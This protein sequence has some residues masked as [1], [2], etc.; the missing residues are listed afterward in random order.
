M[1]S[2]LN[3]MIVDCITESLCFFWFLMGLVWWVIINHACFLL[4]ELLSWFVCVMY[5]FINFLYLFVC[6]YE[7]FWSFWG[8]KSLIKYF[9]G[10]R[11]MKFWGFV[12]IYVVEFWKNTSVLA[13]FRSFIVELLTMPWS[14]GHLNVDH[15]LLITVSFVSFDSMISSLLLFN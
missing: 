15:G 11:C 2:T 7:Y 1:I 12:I 6:M 10:L 13:V 5:V 9:L 3:C 8:Y 4:H 14:L